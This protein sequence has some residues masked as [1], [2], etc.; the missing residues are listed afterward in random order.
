MTDDAALLR[1]YV[2]D[3]SEAAFAEIVQRH[4]GHLHAATVRR[5]HGEAA[6]AEDVVQQ[7]FITLARRAPRLGAH[8]HLAGWLHATAR[9]LTYR[10]MRTELMREL[11]GTHGGA[12]VELPSL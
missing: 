2:R 11:A 9:H 1:R 5:A 4:L 3:H 8:P 12:Y 6:L 7:T 10:A